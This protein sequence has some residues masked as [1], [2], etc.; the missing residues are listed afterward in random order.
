MSI[1]QNERETPVI[2]RRRAWRCSRRTL[3]GGACATVAIAVAGCTVGPDYKQ[4]TTEMPA[5]WAAPT[6][7]P[8]TQNSVAT[9]EPAA[10]VA[11]W[12]GSFNDPVL[13]S[14]IE[15]SLQ[16]NLDLR[17]ATSRIREARASRGVVSSALWPTLDS[18]GSYRRSGTGNNNYGSGHNLY[19]AGLDA[20]WEIDVFGGVRRGVEAAEADITAAVEDRRAVMVT[21]TSEVALNYI[22]LR[23]F[24]RE[25]VIARRNLDTQRQS[26]R[27]TRQLFNNGNGFVSGLDVANAEAQVATTES[28]IPLLE[29][30]ARQSIYA[31]SVL[32]GQQPAAL[33]EE[34]TIHAPIPT[35][36]PTVPVGLPSALLRRRP[37]IRRAEAQL[38]AATALVGVATADLFPRFSLTGS[39]AV[40]GR[41]AD[42]L[43]N[44]NNTLLVARADGELAGL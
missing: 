28:Q 34:L 9:T 5:G 1:H 18:S 25:I 22:D 4:P 10:D 24:Q 16:T 38:H 12:W 31:L 35:A 41:Q 33:V 21:L 14:L 39:F 2:H 43:L 23:G 40:Q 15:R 6:T 3:F 19:Q 11:R 17:Q 26:A 30:D 29:S 36:P 7:A 20:S 13:D 42:S 27:L 44:W 32:L 8:T 37:D